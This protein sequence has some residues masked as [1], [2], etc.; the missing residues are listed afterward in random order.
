[1]MGKPSYDNTDPVMSLYFLTVESFPPWMS[2]PGQQ[3][4]N[5]LGEDSN[6]C[7]FKTKVTFHQ[8]LITE[9]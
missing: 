7:I 6:H 8:N 1:M 4:Y 9:V 2:W 5:T 3:L